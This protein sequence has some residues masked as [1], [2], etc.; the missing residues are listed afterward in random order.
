MI[1]VDIEIPKVEVRFEHLFVEGDAFNGT[2]ALPTLVNSTMNAIQV[3]VLVLLF[4]SDDEYQVN[5]LP[6]PISNF[7]LFFFV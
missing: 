3:L 4:V 2:R 1:R 7:Y 6:S 5:Y